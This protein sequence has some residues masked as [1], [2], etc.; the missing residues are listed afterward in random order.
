MTPPLRPSECARVIGMSPEF[1]RGEIKDG[2][3]RARKYTT[4][5]GRVVYRIDQA[6]FELYLDTHWPER[7]T[8]HNTPCSNSSHCTEE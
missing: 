5:R 6:A 4:P 1:I 7:S 2:R 3:L 8:S